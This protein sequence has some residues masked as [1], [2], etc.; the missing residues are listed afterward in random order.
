MSDTDITHNAIE[1]TQDESVAKAIEK[2][3]HGEISYTDLLKLVA[4]PAPTAAPPAVVPVPKVINPVV[5]AALER[6]PEVYGKVVPTER[7]AIQPAEVT[8]L[9][10][11]R[12]VLKTIENAVTERIA[13]IRTTVL[14]HNDVTFEG[15]H[16]DDASREGVL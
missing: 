1:P 8:T 7:R 13:D 14:N 10:E 12:D 5:R 16:P 4:R 2:I 6:L 9:V 15:E 3:Q 11:E